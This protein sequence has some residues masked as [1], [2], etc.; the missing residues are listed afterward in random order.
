MGGANP[1]LV[2]CVLGELV[3]QQGLS[4]RAGQG[5]G[6]RLCN[7]RPGDS[8]VVVTRKNDVRLLCDGADPS[9]TTSFRKNGGVALVEIPTQEASPL[10]PPCAEATKISNAK[11]SVGGFGARNELWEMP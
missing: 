3:A 8:L 5:T 4:Q 2:V 1:N 9:P 7:F 10:T 11:V 6:I